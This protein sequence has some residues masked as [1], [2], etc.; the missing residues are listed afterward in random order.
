MIFAS[1]FGIFILY[2]SRNEWMWRL[3]KW[4]AY[5][6]SALNFS[7]ALSGKPALSLFAG[8]REGA[9]RHW[10]SLFE[11]LQVLFLIFDLQVVLNC[12]FVRR[13]CIGRCRKQQADYSLL[14]GLPS[15]V[16]RSFSRFLLSLIGKY[17]LWSTTKPL[18]ICWNQRMTYCGW[19]VSCAHNE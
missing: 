11:N 16:R 17:R 19:R 13:K 14:T 15:Q 1:L 9:G 10:E 6:Y 12:L 4:F 8:R 7:I 3:R 18:L 5:S 2:T